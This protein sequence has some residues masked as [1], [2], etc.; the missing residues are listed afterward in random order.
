MLID[1]FPHPYYKGHSQSLSIPFHL[2]NCARPITSGATAG[3]NAETSLKL[4]A[5]G[6]WN[7][8]L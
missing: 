7:K 1:F 3:E 8:H 6:S 5:G 2:N 4:Q